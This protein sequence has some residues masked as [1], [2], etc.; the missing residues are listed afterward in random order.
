MSR[1]GEE[2]GHACLDQ[3]RVPRGPDQLG[4]VGNFFYLGMGSQFTLSMGSAK[5]QG[6]KDCLLLLFN[7]ELNFGARGGIW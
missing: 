1:V 6:P 2:G 7:F 3:L 4:C 5:K